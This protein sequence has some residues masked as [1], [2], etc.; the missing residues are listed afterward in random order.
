MAKLRNVSTPD[1]D[2]VCLA[3]PTEDNC[4]ANGDSETIAVVALNG[5]DVPAVSLAVAPLA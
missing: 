2:H 4:L 3:H 5:K 1:P